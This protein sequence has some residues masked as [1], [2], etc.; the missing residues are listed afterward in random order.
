MRPAGAPA[1]EPGLSF[2]A[3]HPARARLHQCPDPLSGQVLVVAIGFLI[4]PEG[5]E[6]VF[7]AAVDPSN[8][9]VVF[10]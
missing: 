9:L 6:M 8:R 7:C 3:Q 10:R 4:G 5:R 2:Q 1:P